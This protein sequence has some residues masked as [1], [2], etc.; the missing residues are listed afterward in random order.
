MTGSYG[1]ILSLMIANM[2]A[3][4]LARRFRP[5]PIYEALLEQDDIHLPH[6][7]KTP[8]HA[9]EQIKVKDAMMTEVI[10]IRAAST[11]AEAVEQV[12]NTEFTTFPVLNENSRCVGVITEMRL[13]RNLAETGGGKLVGEIA[14]KCHAVYP[15]HLLSRAV[16][17]MNQAKVRQLA[18][19]ER[20]ETR[21][22]LGIITMS[23]IVRAQA[24]AIGESR[25]IDD[26]VAPDF[27]ETGNTLSR[28][29]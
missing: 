4:G 27:S 2:T 14:D 11:V 17:R 15:E 26:T 13:R 7:S 16:V 9:L 23:D 22:F 29:F 6:R 3:Y 8:I 5:V 10:T 20:D 25:D 28:P 18:V 12:K 19:V 21:R 24:E 1:L